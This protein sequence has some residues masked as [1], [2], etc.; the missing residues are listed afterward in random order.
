MGHQTSMSPP[1]ALSNLQVLVTKG[2]E[3]RHQL[4]MITHTNQT[5]QCTPSV[6]AVRLTTHHMRSS[7]FSLTPNY[8]LDSFEQKEKNNME[9]NNVMATSL[10]CL[11]YL[12]PRT[13]L[14]NNPYQLP[15][16]LKATTTRCQHN[17]IHQY[18]QF[19]E[20]ENLSTL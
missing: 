16:G 12:V 2:F 13:L 8:F 7:F 11:W 14:A 18:K 6:A 10:H 4:Q 20:V 17:T 15:R 3:V 9:L 5:K 19:F 1:N